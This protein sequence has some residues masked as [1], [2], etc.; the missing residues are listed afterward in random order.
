[1]LFF[2]LYGGATATALLL[3]VYLLQS[4][5]NIIAPGVTPPARLRRWAVA[6]FGVVALGHGYWLLEY[7]CGYDKHTLLYELLSVFDAVT[8]L[9][10]LFGLMLSML[11]DR[12]RPL[13]PFAAATLPIV[14][15]GALQ[16][17]RPDVDFLSVMVAYALS[18]YTLFTIYMTFAVRQYQ[19]WLRDHYA[20]LEHKEVWASHTLLIMM[21]LCLLNYGFADDSP[22]FLL[23]RMS[24]FGLFSL[25]LW[26]VETLSQLGEVPEQQ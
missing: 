14:V 11:Q 18:L 25:L 19:K 10:T 5:V 21:L 1:M 17:A 8:L 16:I 15:L 20:D 6:F 26:R 2:T 23:I 12:R 3:C 4:K 7:A 9:I 24:D 13:R 22:S